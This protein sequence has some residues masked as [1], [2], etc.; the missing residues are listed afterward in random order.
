M[1]EIDEEIEASI[2]AD[3]YGM[4]EVTGGLEAVPAGGDGDEGGEAT[5]PE[6]PKTPKAAITAKVQAKMGG[7]NGGVQQRRAGSQQ[8]TSG[9]TGA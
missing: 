7:Y 2:D 5:P 3:P 1:Q 8:R 9:R 6:G 4:A